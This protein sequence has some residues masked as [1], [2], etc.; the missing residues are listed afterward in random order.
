MR[1]LSVLAATVLSAAPLAAGAQS[2][3]VFAVNEGV[4]YRITP[5]ETRARYRE[6]ADQL[7]RALRRTVR[8]EA[9][10]DYKVL[11]RGLE[12][13]R[14]DLA[15]I[16]PAHIALLA[17][18]D[19]Q[20]QPVVLTKGWTAYKARFLGPR[21]AKLAR[22][23]DLQGRKI[24][25]PDS[26]SIT[27]WMTR[28]TLRDLGLAP[29]KQSIGTTRYQDG[30]PFMIENGFFSVGVTASNAVVNEWVKRGGSVLFESKPIAI[31]YIV[32]AGRLPKPDID[33]TRQYFIELD[34]S[35]AGR[36]VLD[37]LGFAGFEMPDR[38]TIDEV[39][40]WLGI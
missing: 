4:T 20:Y 25:T 22:P 17:I 33:R 13:R 3:L 1:L 12:E 8:V 34:R 16:H 6:V 26:D 5:H 37:A 9:V 14:Y 19:H 36:E 11:R 15:Y 18:R 24:V 30:I 28:A 21:D 40:K 31:K 2:D 35:P 10:E 32:A 7:G 29:D 23:Q 27:A 38:S 39:T